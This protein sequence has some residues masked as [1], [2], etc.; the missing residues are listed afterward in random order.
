MNIIL[1]N[2]VSERIAVNKT[3]EN[4]VTLTGTLRD[5]TDIRKPTI[6]ITY[7]GILD[8]NYAYIPDFGRYYY[9]DDIVS[10]RT[11]IWRVSMVCDVLMSFKD[12][13]LASPAVIDHTEETSIT[14]YMDSAIWQTLVKTKTDILNFPNGLLETGEYIL[15]TAGGN[16]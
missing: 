11:G 14:E 10:V 8:R 6:L 13:I 3:L 16:Q 15:I 12:D 4:E 1:Y 2:N 7:V 9:I 5:E